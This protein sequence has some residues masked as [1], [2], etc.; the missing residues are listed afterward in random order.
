[1][2]EI[3][4]M[5]ITELSRQQVR[6]PENIDIIGNPF[7]ILC[8][9]IL[10]PRMNRD[11]TRVV[12]AYRTTART[13]GKCCAHDCGITKD[14]QNGELQSTVGGEECKRVK[15]SRQFYRVASARTPETKSVRIIKL[16]RRD[17]EQGEKPGEMNLRRSAKGRRWV[18]HQGRSIRATSSGRRIS[19]DAT[20]GRSRASEQQTTEK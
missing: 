20:R 8:R 7:Q 5:R 1:M 16:T 3:I 18:T 9:F 4:M 14:L 12:H 15:S 17:G 6:A 11:I 10:R 13:L 19:L 2:P